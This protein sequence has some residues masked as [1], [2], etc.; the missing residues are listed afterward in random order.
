M[1]ATHLPQVSGF[2][3]GPSAADVDLDGDIDI[4]VNNLNMPSYLMLNDG[5]GR[6]EI[7]AGNGDEND[8]G[9]FWPNGRIP[10]ELASFWTQFID[11]DSDGDPDLY[12]GYDYGATNR[13]WLLLNDGTGH[14]SDA[15]RRAIPR[16][17]YRGLSDV[18]GSAVADLTGR[19]RNDLL[20]FESPRDRDKGTGCW[21][22]LVSLLI[23]NGN[24]TGASY[25]P[26]LLS[27]VN[28]Y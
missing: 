7:V 15:G 14:F 4:W 27:E 21:S 2:T 28:S 10:P 23:S 11:A 18:Q 5:R 24:G 3:H 1:T 19:G 6:F 16:R 20:V 22:Q 8:P 26:L 17:P 13:P 9:H 12:L 25:P